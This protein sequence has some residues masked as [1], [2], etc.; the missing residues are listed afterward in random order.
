MGRNGHSGGG[1]GGGMGGG[2]GGVVERF[3]L[4]DERPVHS[5]HLTPP[6]SSFLLPLRI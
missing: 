1:I 6:S 5:P 2:G 3:D 4:Y